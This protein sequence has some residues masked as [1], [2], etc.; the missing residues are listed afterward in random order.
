MLE[1]EV[2]LF[3]TP[4]T[5]YAEAICIV[6]APSAFQAVQALFQQEQRFQ[7]ASSFHV[8]PRYRNDQLYGPAVESN[9]LY[10]ERL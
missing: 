6:S 2:I 9:L 5:E 4:E 1:Y 3:L 7:N 10:Q 8:F